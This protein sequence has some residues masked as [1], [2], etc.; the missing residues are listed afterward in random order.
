M[1]A[2]Y[3]LYCEFRDAYLSANS[4]L[5]T[6]V[7]CKKA[8]EQWNSVKKNDDEVKNLIRIWR[9]KAAEKKSRLLT[10][11]TRAATPKTEGLVAASTDSSS[12]AVVTTPD[13]PSEEKSQVAPAINCDHETVE[14]TSADSA[15]TGQGTTN[16]LAVQ[17]DLKKPSTPAQNA[18]RKELNSVCTQMASL[19]QTKN[20]GLWTDD[21][22]NKSDELSKRKSKLE[23][24]LK[25]LAA[26]QVRKQS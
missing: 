23:Q 6:D 16:A 15:Q 25:R 1:D 21:M 14:S 12:D 8:Q 18:T 7:A 5:R 19:L 13:M 9:A 20:S 2:R 11:W 4:D 3:K 22:K 10:I 24:K 26:E 17:Q